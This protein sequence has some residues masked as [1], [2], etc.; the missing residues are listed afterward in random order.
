MRNCPLQ[1]LETAKTMKK[2]LG[3]SLHE[4]AVSTADNGWGSP[5]FESIESEIRRLWERIT[6]VEPE[7]QIVLKRR[8]ADAIVRLTR[9][10]DSDLDN[11]SRRSSMGSLL[12]GDPKDGGKTFPT[13]QPV[14][15][16]DESVLRVYTKDLAT[17][18][19]RHIPQTVAFRT[20]DELRTH[21][22]ESLRFNSIA[23]R[24]R[25]ASYL[26][27]RYFPGETLNTD[28]PRFAAATANTPA[29]GEALF[30]LTCRAERIVAMAAE[31]MIFPS[32]AQGGVTRTAIRAFVQSHLPRSRSAD[33]VGSAIVNTYK[34]F[35]IGEATKSRLN[36]SLREGCLA[37]FAYILHLEFPEPGMQAFEK[38]FEGPMHRWLLWD[39]QWMIRQLYRL[40]ESG[41]LSK[42]SEIDRVRQ[43]TTKYTLGDAMQRIVAL[44]QEPPA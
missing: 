33:E 17:H 34:V 7:H 23:T 36:V 15:R 29:L 3:S 20:V 39:Q 11:L 44:A 4:S 12:F 22:V 6:E 10:V 16:F 8:F 14:P 19:L 26:I 37:S 27:N 38:M 5:A 32:L 25:N 2:R 28:L 1:T 13:R 35:G 31:Q 24:R 9:R 41:L 21:L 40:R 43:F 30:Y 18:A 42:V